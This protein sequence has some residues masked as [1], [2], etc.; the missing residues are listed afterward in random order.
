MAQYKAIRAQPSNHV[1]SPSLTTRTA[2]TADISRGAISIGES[3]RVKEAAPEQRGDERDD[4]RDREGD[5]HG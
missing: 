2:T 3:T 1:D 5:L 4:R